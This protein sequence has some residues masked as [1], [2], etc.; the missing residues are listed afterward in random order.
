MYEHYFD[1]IDE[2]KEQA[3]QLC[4]SL[5][6]YCDGMIGDHKGH[7]YEFSKSCLEEKFH[8]QS[9]YGLHLDFLTDSESE[10]MGGMDGCTFPPCI[11]DGTNA[12]IG[13]NATS[14]DKRIMRAILLHELVHFINDPKVLTFDDNHKLNPSLEEMLNK[15]KSVYD[16]AHIEFPD[17]SG[18]KGIRSFYYWAAVNEVFPYLIFPIDK[19][20]KKIRFFF[21]AVDNRDSFGNINEEN[22][23][24]CIMR[25][26]LKYGKKPFYSLPLFGKNIEGLSYDET[27]KLS[28]TKTQFEDY[29]LNIMGYLQTII[30]NIETR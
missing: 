7:R 19:F 14:H 30:Q 27:G 10:I 9:P 11:Y 22:L 23:T 20:S 28:C 3:E 2:L 15:W 12:Y 5:L 17:G 24:S 29:R 13:I 16:Y 8:L 4:S 6:S 18:C 26:E 25:L 1:G 21:H